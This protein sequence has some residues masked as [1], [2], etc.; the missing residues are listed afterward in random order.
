MIRSVLLDVPRVGTTATPQVTI[1]IA[2]RHR[3][4]ELQRCLEALERQ[5]T[6]VAYHINVVDDGGS[7]DR[8]ALEARFPRV[9]VFTSGGIGPAGARNVGVGAA[10]GQVVAFTDDDTIPTS[11]WVEAIWT[12]LG[13]AASAVAVEGPTD[14]PAFDHL[15][16]HSVV[17]REGAYITANIAYRRDVLNAIGGFDPTYPY[18]HCEDRDLAFRAL[19]HGII[20][21]EPAMRVI[22]PSRP[23]KLRDLI[24]RARMLE[25]ELVLY[26]RFPERFPRPGIVPVE[27][28][29]VVRTCRRWLQIAWR[30]RRQLVV[31]PRRGWRLAAVIIGQTWITLGIAIRSR[32]SRGRTPAAG[33]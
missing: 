27:A 9:R 32:F 14:S 25:S 30:E 23:E 2:T 4:A 20:E 5:D 1:V 21:W 24:G 3:P 18:P 12:G 31:S 11:R 15:Y 10:L 29:L 6:S 26:D 8:S 28:Q 17:G 19:D 16:E 22:H 13:R 33:P 7:L